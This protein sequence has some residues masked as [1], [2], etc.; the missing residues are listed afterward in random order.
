VAG[1]RISQQV[2]GEDAWGQS[3]PSVTAT[4]GSPTLGRGSDAH[5]AA[6]FEDA[7]RAVLGGGPCVRGGPSRPS[8]SPPPQE[9]NPR[10]KPAS[11]RLDQVLASLQSAGGGGGKSSPRFGAAPCPGR[12]GARAAPGVRFRQSQ[13]CE[14]LLRA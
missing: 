9:F 12:P 11:F 7:G 5:R 10:P 4:M 6:G 13:K 14:F 8:S 1:T 2:S 3:G